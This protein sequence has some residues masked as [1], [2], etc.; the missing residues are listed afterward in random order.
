MVGP[1]SP[2]GL[3]DTQVRAFCATGFVKISPSLPQGFHA[4]LAAQLDASQ[5]S[6]EPGDFGGNNI[7]AECPDLARIYSDPAVVA[8]AESL[9][10]PGCA[11][12]Y[13][14]HLHTIPAGGGG[15]GQAW[16][17]DD[18]VRN[19][20][21]AE[22]VSGPVVLMTSQ[23]TGCSDP[24]CRLLLNGSTTTRRCGTSTSSGRSSRCT[25]RRQPQSRWARPRF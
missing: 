24:C 20:Q 6:A 11:L 18:Y 25:T 13:H 22:R 14:R 7:L 12:H 17:K 5:A 23:H 2:L 16:H 10:G 1:A 15:G 8:A 3:T 19:P 9:V 4:G 21:P